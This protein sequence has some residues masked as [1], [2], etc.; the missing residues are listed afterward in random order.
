MKILTV[1][2]FGVGSSMV[3]KSNVEKILDELSI[4]AE[5]EN[6]DMTSANSI[7]CDLILTGSDLYETVSK[8]VKVPVI[9]IEKFMDRNELRQKLEQYF[10]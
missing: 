5:V 6:T 9:A 8:S 3:L 1:C 10:K 2:G 7:N 4:E